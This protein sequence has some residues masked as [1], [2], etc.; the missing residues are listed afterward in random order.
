MTSVTYSYWYVENS[1]PELEKKFWEPF[2]IKFDF[3][4]P[5]YL[6]MARNWSKS[7][8][9]VCERGLELTNDTNNFSSPYPI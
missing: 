9:K 8:R 7:L 6:M 5:T 4:I 3:K 1:N 2:L